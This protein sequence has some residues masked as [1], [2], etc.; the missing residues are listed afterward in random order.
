MNQNLISNENDIS[1][2][3]GLV[4]KITHVHHF[5]YIFLHTYPKIMKLMSLE[6]IFNKIL[7]K[8]ESL[9]KELG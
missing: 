1:R 4:L 2:I 5:A 6:N 9:K 8:K 7:E 3:L